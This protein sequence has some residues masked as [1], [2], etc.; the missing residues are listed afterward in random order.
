MAVLDSGIDAL[1]PDLAGRLV[2]GRNIVVGNDETT[3]ESG[4]GTIMAGIIGA[5]TNN[6][7]GMAGVAWAAK[8]MPVKVTNT[9]RRGRRHQCGRRDPLGR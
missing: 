7:L 5:I 4:H 3:D 2:P 1:H 9:L 8:I 6:G